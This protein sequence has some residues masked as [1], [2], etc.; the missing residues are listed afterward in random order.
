MEST[1]GRVGTREEWKAARR[2]QH[3]SGR[4]VYNLGSQCVK[5]SNLPGFSA[6]VRDDSGSIFY[7]YSTYSRGVDMMNSTYQYLD[8]VVKGRDEADGNMAWLRR[9]DEYQG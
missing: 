8:L 6:F 3:R 4:P 1:R 9:R 2:E 5:S 7:T